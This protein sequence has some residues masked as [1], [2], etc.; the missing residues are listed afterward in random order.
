VFA[1]SEE[2]YK[3]ALANVKDGETLVGKVVPE[4]QSTMT[5]DFPFFRNN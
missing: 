1:K 5:F 3:Q 4:F 2:D